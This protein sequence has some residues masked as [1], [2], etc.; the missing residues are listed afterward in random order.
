MHKCLSVL[1]TISCIVV[2]NRDTGI[3]DISFS[4][5]PFFKQQF[6][7]TCMLKIA[8]IITSIH[9]IQNMNMKSAKNTSI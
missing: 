1:L 2:D 7:L 3:C 9:L 6:W 4:G 8:D 5:S